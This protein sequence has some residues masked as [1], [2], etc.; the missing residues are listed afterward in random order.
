MSSLSVFAY[1]PRL[2]NSIVVGILLLVAFWVVRPV[3]AQQTLFNVPSADVTDQAKWFYQY[4]SGIRAW[5]PNQNWTQSHSMG[6]GIGHHTDVD[7]TLSGLVVPQTNRLSVGFGSKTVLPINQAHEVAITVGQLYPILFS[8]NGRLGYYYYTHLSARLPKINTRLTAGAY[9]G[10][11][12]LFGR[13]SRGFLVGVEQ[14]LGKRVLFQADWY[15]GNDD[16]GYFIPGVVIPLTKA[17]QLSLGY[18]LPTASRTH[19]RGGFIA[20]I[21][22]FTF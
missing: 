4:Q 6:Y 17:L 5:Q 19:H 8:K 3:F 21:T 15:T 9:C 20:S 1:H 16:E 10:D 12:V 14:P 7:V 13:A 2:L 22:A 11:K 18:A